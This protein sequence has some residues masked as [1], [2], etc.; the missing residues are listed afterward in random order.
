MPIDMV[1]GLVAHAWPS[2]LLCANLTKEINTF[3]TDLNMHPILT[4]CRAL[5]SELELALIQFANDISS[6]AHVQVTIS[7]KTFTKRWVLDCG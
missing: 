3:V 1:Q 2:G 5:K 4:K 7:S 6:E